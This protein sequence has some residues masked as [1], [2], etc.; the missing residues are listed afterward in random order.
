MDNGL[1]SSYLLLKSTEKGVV[2]FVYGVVEV[3]L[4]A[5]N[6]TWNWLFI[7]DISACVIVDGLINPTMLAWMMIDC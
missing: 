5:G 7:V 3:E 6:E 2:S 1:S 4:T